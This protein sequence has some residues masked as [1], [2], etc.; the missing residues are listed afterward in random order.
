MAFDLTISEEN[1]GN[2]NYANDNLYFSANVSYGPIL[3]DQI[4]SDAMEIEGNV[5]KDDIIPIYFQYSINSAEKYLWNTEDGFFYSTPKITHSFVASGTYVLAVSIIS[6]EQF[7]NGVSFRFKY[8]FTK[9]VS[10]SSFFYKMIIKNMPMWQF[11]PNQ[12]TADL[13]TASS[14]FF[15][16]IYTDI[17]GLYNLIDV[18]KV[19]PKYF[20]YFASTLGHNL[21]YAKKV[22]GNVNDNSFE[23]YDIFQRIK[24]G[25]ATTSEIRKFRQFLLMS[26]DI[27]RTGG[28]PDQVKKFL[29]LFTID[30]KSIDLWT[31]YW[32]IKAK[33]V[34]NEKF[35]GLANFEE[36]SLKLK[37]Q[38]IR[39]VGN[40]NDVGHLINEFNSF[41]ID[42]YHSVQKITYPNDTFMVDGIYSYFRIS[43]C[44]PIFKD[45]RRE[46]GNLIVSEDITSDYYD[47]V[48]NEDT[49]SKAV[50]PWI[51]KVKT[52]YL[53][54]GDR[55]SIKYETTDEPIYDSI[56][57]NVE[58]AVKNMTFELKFKYL[59]IPQTYEDNNYK[60]QDNEIFIAFR[61]IKS[62][63][64]MYDNFNE[65]YRLSLNAKRSTV[66][67]AKVIKN[68]AN[69]E[70]ITQ[71]IS[72][73]Q[74]DVKNPIFEKLILDDAGVTSF[75]FNT[76]YDL[77]L[78]AIDSTVSAYYKESTEFNEITNKIESNEGEVPFGQTLSTWI[79]LFENVNIDVKELFIFSSDSAEDAI[80]AFPYTSILTE[81]YFGVGVRNSSVEILEATLDNMDMEESLYSDDEKEINLKPKY[82]EWQNNKLL[83]FNSSVESVSTFNKIITT[84]F[85]ASVKQ[86]PINENEA[87]AF[88]FIYFDTA[89]LSEE[90]A[91]RYTVTFDKEWVSSNFVNEQD[92]MNKIIVPFGS[93]A[94]WFT[95]ESR[96][97]DVEFYK[98]YFGETSPNHNFGTDEAPNLKHAPGFFT[99]N[100]STTLGLYK[101]EPLDSFS[102]VTRIDTRDEKQV[103]IKSVFKA[104]DKIE[105]YKLSNNPIRMRGLFEEVCPNSAIFSS[106]ALCGT[107]EQSSEPFENTLFLP[108]VVNNAN[109]QRIVGVRFKHC[110]DIKNIIARIKDNREEQVDVQMY[111][112]FVLQLPIES[113][114]FRPDVSK[115]LEVYS[116]DQN[117][118]IVKMFVPLGILNA[119]IQNYSLG[120]EYMHNIDNSGSTAITLDSVYVKVPREIMIYKEQENIFELPSFNP[121]E[122]DET[123]MKCK[124]FLSADLTLSTTLNDYE[125]SYFGIANKYMMHYDFRKM[126]DGLKKTGASF[127]SYLWWIPKELWRKRDF[128]VMA[129]DVNSD[130]ATGLNYN[131][132]SDK[133]F[134][135]KKVVQDSTLYSLR[136]KLKDGAV[137]PYSTYYAKVKFRMSWSGF[138]ELV[139]GNA[140]LVDGTVKAA[141]PLTGT[142][143][144]ELITVGGK[145]TKYLNSMPAPV[146]ECMDFYVPISWYPEG[147]IS[148]DNIIE[149]GNYIKGVAGDIS[150]PSVTLTPYGLMTYFVM[151]A[152]NSNIITEDILNVTS[153]W[154]IEDWNERFLD[155]ITIEYI[156]EAI[157]SDKYKL[158]DDF[159]FATKY[160]SLNGSRVNVEY[161]AGDIKEWKVLETVAM[162]PKAYNSYYFKVPSALNS[163]SNWYNDVTT[164]K[165]FNYIV[166]FDLYSVNGNVITLSN[167]NLYNIMQTGTMKMQLSYD[168]LFADSTKSLTFTDDFYKTRDVKWI[169]YQE[170]HI[171][172][173]LELSIRNPSEDLFLKGS[174]P[175][176][177]IISLDGINVLQNTQGTT[178]NVYDPLLSGI[179]YNGTNNVTVTRDEN[180]GYA[181]TVALIDEQNDVYELDTLVLFDKQLNVTKGYSGKKFEYIIKANTVFNSTTNT[182]VLS[183]YYFVGIGTYNFDI[184]LGV[185]KYNPTTDKME[186]TFLAG[187]GDYNSNNIKANT[188]YRLKTVVDGEN[189]RVIFNEEQ[190]A[191]RMVIKYNINI[192]YQK[193][194]NKYLSGQF[195]EL[196]YLVTGLDKLKI[197]YPD[198]LKSIAGDNFYDNNW[199]E[200]WAVNNRPTGPYC[201]IK[202]FNPY[203]YVKSVSYKARIQ[204]DKTFATSNEQVDLNA[205]V[206]EIEKNYTV[207]GIVETVSKTANGGII[208]KYGKDLFHKMPNK[209]VAKRYGGVDKVFVVNNKIVIRFDSTN[210]LALVITDETFTVIQNVYVKDNSFNSDHIYKYMVWTEREIDNIYANSTN[211]YVTFKDI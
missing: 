63:S 78:I 14:R 129:L 127:D 2:V 51:L 18:E 104:N 102:S 33:G 31:Q 17:K 93:Q 138:D 210:K 176:L 53:E 44:T 159:G 171:K 184:A 123:S 146:A 91:S 36:N 142:E 27:F 88:K 110:T 32:G 8:T 94:S 112:L 69:D 137:T 167:D 87:N 92:V 28:T 126:L 196:V 165:V 71:K 175:I 12:A 1:G 187:F 61:G 134:Y 154:T 77:K 40:N 52:E 148:P 150:S 178:E 161:D 194:I 189:I 55:I 153:G 119:E 135:G 207:S 42:N 125:R 43:H 141:R 23:Q 147:E 185:A 179:S 22:G 48:P 177:K 99:Y 21:D 75:K 73:N 68:S 204:E 197:T 192:N 113:V 96:T 64:E 46:D 208:I 205:I 35:V 182:F 107:V 29:S 136:I 100:Q 124:Y 65:Y 13:V 76:A 163:L 130:I 198:K 57:A 6:E 79:P 111:G 9:N 72:L 211:L 56:V 62:N 170:N 3:L 34:T 54:D 200:S 50:Y 191:D 4:K 181:K 114:K 202:L 152:T 140:S 20:E 90:V 193:D 60:N 84:N 97:Y 37:W 5:S 89:P 26:V 66:S 103:L 162:L 201:G 131:A 24:N 160:A 47:I 195:E 7:F 145:A 83:S 30:A 190:E 95:N 155:F 186:K 149:W 80:A 106:E 174:D 19:D 85:D 128:E 173:V 158:Y 164:V 109:S 86:Y 74:G 58:D 101:T 98:N 203:T 209:F 122:D 166:P 41:V 151:H 67:L 183:S 82:L 59:S 108:I 70:I 169:T 180:G 172:D 133:Y 49:D 132:E 39:V 25:V 105:Q 10:V 115:E 206:S 121:Y 157:P 11:E 168:A 120:T 199:N 144:S 45:I 117:T 16:K 139:L 118:V 143:A 38:D 15:D 116:E 188:W 156:A 81:G